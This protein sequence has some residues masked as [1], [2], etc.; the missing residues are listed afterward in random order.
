MSTPARRT[1]PRRGANA[2]VPPEHPAADPADLDALAA[3][4]ARL[5]V[6]FGVEPAGAI[7]NV[8]AL[9]C[10]TARAAPHDERLF[11]CAAS[12]LARHH[13]FVNGRRLSALAAALDGEASAVLGALLSLA[14]EGAGAAP[15]LEAAR[16]RCRPLAHPRP[17]FAAMETMRVLRERVR[18]HA[19]PAFAAWGLWHDAALKPSAVRPAAWLLHRVPELR[20]RALLGPSVEADLMAHALAAEVTVRD[21]ARMALVSYAAAHSAADRLVARGLLTRERAAQ[22]QVLRPTPFAVA[23]LRTAPLR[24]SRTTAR[25]GARPS[26]VPRGPR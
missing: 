2:S 18:R 24:A 4:W 15:E 8:E 3:A 7:V 10:V 22:R 21:V 13:G 1:P 9:I 20:V 6:L 17:L 5:G 12:W 26:N 14:R 11:V 16:A 25:S 23:A 19:L